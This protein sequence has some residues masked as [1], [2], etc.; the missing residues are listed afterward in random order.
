ME[1]QWMEWTSLGKLPCA[2]LNFTA[3]QELSLICPKHHCIKVNCPKHHCTL[4]CTASPILPASGK[5]RCKGQN[6]ETSWGCVGPSG[7]PYVQCTG[8]QAQTESSRT[9]YTVHCTLYTVH[10]MYTIHCTLHSVQNL[11]LG[12]SPPGPPGNPQGGRDQ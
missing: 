10:Y 6:V 2:A 11:R 1:P 8:L 5:L 9:L 3:F 12:K 7:N 4:K